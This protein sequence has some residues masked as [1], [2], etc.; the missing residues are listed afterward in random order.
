VA[1][2]LDSAS[3]AEARR[4]A[5]LGFIAGITTNPDLLHAMG[6]HTLSHQ[7]IEEFAQAMG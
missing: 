7:A 6:D 2:C 5:A 1:L 3:V 4:A